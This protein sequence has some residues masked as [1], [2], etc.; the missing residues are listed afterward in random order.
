[1]SEDET[2]DRSKEEILKTRAQARFWNNLADLIH[3]V[4]KTVNE[5]VATKL[6]R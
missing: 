1:M 4:A 6:K 3:A 5:S 2:L